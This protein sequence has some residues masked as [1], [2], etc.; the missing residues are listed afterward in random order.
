MVDVPN[1]PGGITRA[2][3]LEVRKEMDRQHLTGVELASRSHL[4]RASLSRWIR[5]RRAMTAE[6]LGRVAAGLGL[7]AS[8]LLARAESAL[9]RDEEFLGRAAGPG[10][11]AESPARA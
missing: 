11:R 6:V 2:L 4:D 1:G 5:G 7:T 8:E 3:A 9:E 10:H